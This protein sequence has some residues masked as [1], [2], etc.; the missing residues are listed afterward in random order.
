MR[1]QLSNT[2]VLLL[3]AALIAACSAITPTE[4]PAPSP[5]VAGPATL[6]SA[7]QPTAP[8]TA[9]APL[10][11]ALPT[12]RATVPASPPTATPTAPPTATQWP[13]PATPTAMPGVDEVIASLAGLSLD[14]FLEES[15]KQWVL[16]SPRKLTELGLSTAFGQRN[17]RL[18]DLTDDYVRETQR[19]EAAIL[20]LLRGYDRT[21]LSPKQQV[22]YDAYE[23]FLDSRVRGH[24]FTY[25][26]YPLNGF[27]NGYVFRL[28]EL[29]TE[30]HPL[31]NRQ[32]AEDY[33]ARL[34]QVD[35]QVEQLLEGL[36][37]R[38]EIDVIAPD[39]ILW[40]AKQ[41]ILRSLGTDTADRATVRA[42]ALAVY[43]AFGDAL[44]EMEDLSDEEK[45]AFLEAALNEIRNSYIPALL[46][47]L[48]TIDHQA[49]L[50]TDEA[51]VWK[52]PNGDAYYAYALRQ[53]T[54]TDLTPEQVHEIGLAEVAR[55][56]AELRE[57][58]DGLGYPQDRPVGE[59]I[60]RTIGEG[61]TV[62]SSQV[63]AAYEAILAD[64]DQR[65]ET[66]FDLRPQAPVVVVGEPAVG[67]YYTPGA[68]DGSRP[69]AFHAF[70]GGSGANK[71]EMPT[72]AYHEAVPGHHFQ[73][74]LAREMELPT[75]SKYEFL[76]AHVEGWALYAERLAWELGVYDD[77]PHGN[78]GRL[79]LELLRAARL[80]VDTGIHAM[81]WTRDQARSYLQ[82]NVG[83]WTH[84]VE[85]YVVLPAQATGYK[86]GMI[87]ILELRQRA[88]DQLGDRFDLK[89][90]HN[91]VLGNG[92][93]PLS[94]L[95]RLVDE[96]IDAKQQQPGP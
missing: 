34:S 66:A 42:P 3:G 25:H 5:I 7:T 51:G 32:D 9:R 43:T 58:F 33:V 31:E 73:D 95:E 83:G 76:N 85:R 70:V 36:A 1:K 21:T 62:E 49:T 44:R 15:Y 19:L 24:E 12:A 79:R 87:K 74:A 22:T 82:E 45:T 86:I 89:E 63:V 26:N 80:V 81:R 77:D 16:R 40:Y 2:L 91:V 54:S 30:L 68:A 35:D 75:F 20:D 8:P 84:E 88:M 55:I 78:V 38:E 93:L 60:Q 11:T 39:F 18:D 94:V 72:I 53:E 29:L 69:A 27:P 67:G 41:D 56:Q 57:V 50:A 37:L 61:G 47:L 92:C 14:E 64:I 59:L 46:D 28:N 10:A 48:S 4:S 96:Y 52:L 65:V 6:E 13:T 90:F 71:A 17:N 23:W